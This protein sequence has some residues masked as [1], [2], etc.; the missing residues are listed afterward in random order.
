M[1][2]T[3][4]DEKNYNSAIMCYVCEREFSEEDKNYIKVRDHN[5]FSGEYRGAAHCL[6]NLQ[7]REKKFIP[8]IFHNLKA[9]D[10]HIF[11]KAFSELED[12]PDC[13]PQNTEKMISFSLKKKHSFELRFLDSYGFMG[14]PLSTLVG[15]LKEFPMMSRFFTENEIRYL[16]R[17]GVFPYEWLD[18]FDKLNNPRFPHHKSFYSNLTGENIKASDYKLAKEI[19][20][21]FCKTVKDY[22]DLYLKT[23]V[24][25]L[26]DVFE[27]FRTICYN[28]FGLDPLN[29]FT[30][31]GFAWDCLLKY[32]G[33]ELE[34]LTQ[35]DMYLLFERG[36]RGGYSNC[37]KNYSKANHKYLPNFNPEEISKFLMYY[38]MNS[39]YP[40]VM[41]EPMPAGGFRWRA[42][43]ELDNVFK[44]LKS[45]KYDKVPPC[46]D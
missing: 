29:Y 12:E 1:I 11:I 39:L 40:T 6:C 34:A 46:T 25:L 44:L 36:I 41:A 5:H 20:I 9:Y 31:P 26:A 17:K 30:S 24:L 4:E 32:S 21:M 28:A 38:N 18:K 33:V 13:I 35:E 23:D 8:V 3:E 2:F 45:G 19:F 7:L 22:H 42:Q 14:F 27:E 43:K 10:S 37:H 16:S 15:N